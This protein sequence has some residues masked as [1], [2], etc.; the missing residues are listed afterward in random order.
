[1][2]DKNYTKQAIIIIII[3]LAVTIPFINQ[4][5]HIDDWVYLTAAIK[6][7][8]FGLSAIYGKS[9]EMGMLFPNYYLTHPFLWPLIITLFIKIF[10][11]IKE[12]TLHILSIA[13]LIITGLSAFLISKRFS[14]RPLIIT[15]LFIFM[16]SLM[17]MSHLIMTDVSTLGFFLLAIGLHIEGVKKRSKILL[18]LSGVA[19]TISWGLSYQA[20][21]VLFLLVYYNY[22]NKE[23]MWW[24]YSSVIIPFVFFIL[25]FVFTW[26]KFGIPHPLVSFQWAK[27]SNT[28]TLQSLLPKLLANINSLGSSV[29]FPFLILAV[30]FF[31][32]RFRKLLVLTCIFSIVATFILV[33]N[34][35]KIDKILFSIYFSAGLFFIIRMVLL[36]KDSLKTK[37]KNFNFLSIWFIA[38][39]VVATILLP[40]GIP[41]YLLPGYLP[42]IIV[43]TI[44]ALEL[45]NNTMFKY[46]LLAGFVITITWGTLLSIADYQLA[47]VYRQFAVHMKSK[48]SGEKVWFSGDSGFK[49]YMEKEGFHYLFVND[50]RPATGDLIVI[51]REPWPEN[52][53]N[54]IERS[55]LIDDDKYY[56]SL[57]FRTL[58]EKSHAGF[59]TQRSGLLT[60]SISSDALEKFLIYRI[61]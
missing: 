10:D 33:P 35:P 46:L 61:N 36:L 22:L 14:K 52:M 57:P 26:A 38:F 39:F 19:A 45:F 51:P 21:F 9:E 20:L 49:W 43:F 12:S 3:C 59:Y 13:S 6:F 58:N 42:V 17:I 29:V 4:A 5:Y 15:L 40:L 31:A 48:Y 7:K 2:R 24:A 28:R 44:D 23:K 53:S 60:F 37:D 47:G 16:P 1:M 18:V 41:R 8:K 25:W 34:Y 54:L 50:K 55:K 27:V 56:T 32:K 30:Y 11:S